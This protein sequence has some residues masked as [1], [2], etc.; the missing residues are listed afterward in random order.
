M[1]NDL[2][3]PLYMVPKSKRPERNCFKCL[4]ISHYE[5]APKFVII[6]SHYSTLS[7][8]SD[9]QISLLKALV[10]VIPTVVVNSHLILRNL[11]H[12]EVNPLISHQ[13]LLTICPHVGTVACSTPGVNNVLLLVILASNVIRLATLHL[14]VGVP[15]LSRIQGN[16][17]G[18][19]VEAEHPEV[20]VLPPDD[21]SMKQQKCLNL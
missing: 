9:Q 3:M 17:V 5:T 2:W 10:D 14:Y 20:E 11:V 18:H 13:I 7:V 15:V 12:L 19:V 21:K 6:M 16:S 4:N 8:W 1:K